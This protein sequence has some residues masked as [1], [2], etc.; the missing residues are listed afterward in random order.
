MN[1]TK[2][3][4]SDNQNLL[5]NLNE[6]VSKLFLITYEIFVNFSVIFRIFKYL[7]EQLRYFLS[8]EEFII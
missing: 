6:G 7:N 1:T 5:T 8:H 2:K 3:F 4:Y